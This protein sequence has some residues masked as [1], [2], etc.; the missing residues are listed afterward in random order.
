MKNRTSKI[1]ALI[2][3]I[4]M[5]LSLVPFG[6]VITAGAAES[7][8]APVISLSNIASTGKIKL[9]WGKV[10]GAVAYKVYR[11]V[12]ANSGY[13]LIKTTPNL[14][15]TNTSATAGVSYYYKVK[16]VDASGNTSKYSGYKYRTCDIARPVISLSTE[17]SSGKTKISWSKVDGAVSYNVFRAEGKENAY[18]L[19]QNTSSL[20]CLDTTAVPGKVYY[21]KVKALAKVSA[22]DSAYSS[23]KYRTCH[24]AAP[25]ASVSLNSSNKPVVSW[26]KVDG[27]VSYKLYRSTSQDGKY[28]LIKQTTSTKV[29]NVSVS[30]STVYYYKVKAL[31]ENS[32]ADSAYSLIVTAG[33][34]IS[35]P[36]TWT[37][38]QIVDY[39]KAAAGNTK[40][41]SYQQMAL[42]GKL[43]G[44]LSL[45]TGEV[46]DALKDSASSFNGITGGYSKLVASDLKSA[47]ARSE[48][49]YVYINLNPKDQTD[50]EHGV[51]DEG[52]V[53]HVIFVIGG[54]AEAI[55]ELGYEAN[56]PEGSIQ[57]TYTNAYAKDIKINTKTGVIENGSWGYDVAIKLDGCSIEGYTMKNFKA[58]VEYKVTYPAP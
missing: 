40:G 23:A 50:N 18:S 22:A 45:F 2:M 32:A 27:A 14:S 47:S 37:T 16:A 11:A 38:Q 48:G 30:E 1:L 35:D 57:F 51:A 31:A 33:T 13:N 34:P 19:I 39:Y 4:S 36:S 46:N 52:T 3:A 9:S 29:T 5:I 26:N 41:Q 54:V 44:M 56:I 10:P 55:D 17:S 28:S 15:L 53:G 12:G 8:S 7:V 20:N 42:K 6:S 25:V 21:Y 49:D 43:P 24:L 58:N